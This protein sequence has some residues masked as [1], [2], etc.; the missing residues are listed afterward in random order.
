M[1]Y[2]TD[3]EGR[4]QL[5]KPLSEDQAAYLTAFA[6]TRRIKRNAK[7]TA[8]RADPLRMAVRLPA[9]DEGGYF[10]SETGFAGQ[11]SGDDVLEYSTAPAGQPGLWCQWTPTED[12]HGIEWDGGEK[13]YE[14]TAWLVYIIEN[15]L[16]PWGL[17][18]DGEVTWQGQG[19]DDLGQLCVIGNLVHERQGRVVYG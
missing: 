9:G 17:I 4:F 14:Y 13:F 12:R 19:P 15:F 7:K 1:G 16:K 10:V 3:F 2:T 5:N 11:E 6:S 18:L 8:K